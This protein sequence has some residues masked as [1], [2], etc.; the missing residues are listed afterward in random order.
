VRVVVDTNVL[1]SAL[2]AP[3]SPPATL[4][5]LGRSGRFV[6]LC[7]REKIEEFARVARYPKLRARLT[8][9]L[10][11][12]L[13]HELRDLAEAVGP[14]PRVD[15]SAD[16][17]DN[18]LLAMAQAGRADCLVTGDRRGLLALGRHGATRIVTV[19]AF[20]ALVGAARRT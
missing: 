13:V 17:Y 15:R 19:V 8:L 2:L 20:L 5:G 14:L 18:F 6:L 1:V 9:A 16:P 7:A 11:G 4:V 12:K 10:A 3:T